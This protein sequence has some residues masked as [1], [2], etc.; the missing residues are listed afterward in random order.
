MILGPTPLGHLETGDQGL[1]VALKGGHGLLGRLAALGFTPGATVS[2]VRN[3]G[4]GPIIVRVLDTQIALGR[5]QA[6]QI[7]V[8]RRHAETDGEI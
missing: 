1:V 6:N 5:G 4:H 3:S 8:Q 7:H 2:V